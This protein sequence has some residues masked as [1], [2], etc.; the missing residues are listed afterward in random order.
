MAT[1][2]SSLLV[3]Y[4]K[5]SDLGYIFCWCLHL[6]FHPKLMQTLYCWQ[7]DCANQFAPSTPPQ[8]HLNHYSTIRAV[9][10]SVTTQTLSY[11]REGVR[12]TK[13]GSSRGND[14]LLM[15]TQRLPALPDSDTGVP[16][17]G[18]SLEN[19]MKSS[20]PR[21][22]SLSKEVELR[23]S[24][25]RRRGWS[26]VTTGGNTGGPRAIQVWV[27]SGSPTTRFAPGFTLPEI[28]MDCPVCKDSKV[29]PLSEIAG[30]H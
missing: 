14:S 20:G 30:I 4:R 16:G 1:A 23:S 18:L 24:H 26:Y 3:P 17:C 25:R 13:R 12:V 22:M 11:S 10:S 15:K 28:P 7:T 8:S 6:L 5:R 9:S 27:I 29:R 19:P 2:I 21:S